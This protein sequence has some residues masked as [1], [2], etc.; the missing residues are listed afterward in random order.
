MA[1]IPTIVWSQVAHEF[2]LDG[3]LRDIYVLETGIAE[4]HLVMEHLRTTATY[5]RFTLDFETVPMPARVEEVFELRPKASPMLAV[6]LGGLLLTSHFFTPNEIEFSFDP[7]EVTSQDVLDVLL[8]F[9]RRLGQLTGCTV[10]VTFENLL[11]KP[12]F[13]LPSGSSEVAYISADA[14][15]A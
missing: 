12:I 13:R 5:F 4:W 11:E 14:T 6:D 3:T 1:Q 8:S 7:E 9:V 2:E 15:E 10:L